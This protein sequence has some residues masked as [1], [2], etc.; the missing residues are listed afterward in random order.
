[1]FTHNHYQS[2][3]AYMK[4]T[5][6]TLRNVNATVVFYTVLIYLEIFI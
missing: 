5:V 4:K 6:G 1:M 2:K 3:T